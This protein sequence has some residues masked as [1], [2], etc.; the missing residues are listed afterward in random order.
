M[1][2]VERNGV[3]EEES[4]L[5]SDLSKSSEVEDSSNN[6]ASSKPSSGTPKSK[7]Y[8]QGGKRDSARRKQS[9]RQAEFL[10]KQRLYVHIFK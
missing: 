3:P 9:V 1:A 5:A 6:S 7:N 4:Q 8:K 10:E 2:E